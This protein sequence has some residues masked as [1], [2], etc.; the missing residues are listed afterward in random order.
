MLRI[1]TSGWQ[2]QDWRASFY[3]KGVVQRDWL[4][5][6]AHRFA[7]VELNNSFYRLPETAHFER[8]RDQTPGDFLMAVKMSQYLT[9]M[10]RL[11]DPAA[12]VALFVERIAMLGG[13]LGPV[14][15]QLPPRM[16]ADPERLG[17]ALEQFPT[18]VRLAV[19]FR[20]ESWFQDRVRAVLEQRGAAL[21]LADSPQLKVPPWRTADW[22]FVRFHQGD[23]MPFPCYAEKTLATWAETI[24]SLWRSEADVFCY[25]NNDARACAVRDAITFAGVARRTGL[26]PSRVPSAAEVRVR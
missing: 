22:G 20:A 13:K 26:T 19:E 2:Y 10:K 5:F 14:L 11:R 18:H 7:T 21:C 16:A 9:H 1:G 17:D 3:P 4:A 12:P 6:Y 8:W 25:F 15:L 23:G 24:A